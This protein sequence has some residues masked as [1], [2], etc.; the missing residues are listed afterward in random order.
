MD[1]IVYFIASKLRMPEYTV[2]EG[3][4]ALLRLVEQNVDQETFDRLVGEIPGARELLN[5]PDQ[6]PA[7]KLADVDMLNEFLSGVRGLIAGPSEDLVEILKRLQGA[8]LELTQIQPFVDAFLEKLEV[9]AGNEPVEIIRSTLA[10][11]IMP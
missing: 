6:E 8:G 7:G 9:E 4:K 1:T 11:W 3:I 2:R 5:E 10:R